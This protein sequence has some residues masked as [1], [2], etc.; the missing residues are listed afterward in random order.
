MASWLPRPRRRV[1]VQARKGFEVIDLV[2]EEELVKFQQPNTMESDWD[3]P[4]H[5]ESTWR[6]LAQDLWPEAPDPNA[7]H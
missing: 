3:T 6:G 2:T 7:R 4:V 5:T 1:P